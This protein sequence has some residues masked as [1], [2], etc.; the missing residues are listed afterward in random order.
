[1]VAWNLVSKSVAAVVMLLLSSE[2]VSVTAADEATA[3]RPVL[4]VGEKGAKESYTEGS[5]TADSEEDRDMDNRVQFLQSRRAKAVLLHVHIPKAG[6]TA[7]AIALSSDCVCHEEWAKA[8]FCKKCPQ[9]RGKN[10][11]QFD[12]SV[13]RAT[14]WLFGVHL[15]YAVMRSAVTSRNVDLPGHGLTPVYAVMLR[16]PFER[17]VSE[18]R[19]W[20]DQKHMRALDWALTADKPG[21]VYHPAVHIVDKLLLRQ[22]AANASESER[23]GPQLTDY[24][25]EYAQLPPSFIIQN[26]QAKMVGGE[27]QDFDM[28]FDSSKDFGSRWRP[29]NS[30]ANSASYYQRALQTLREEPTVLLGLH[31]RFAE[32]ICLLEVLFGDQHGFKWDEGRNSHSGE[33]FNLTVETSARQLYPEVY[34]EWAR[35]NQEDIKLYRMAGQL[36][37]RQFRAALRL[38]RQEVESGG[39]A[40]VPHCQAFLPI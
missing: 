34:S 24:M 21:L 25:M 3:L 6:G 40:S 30:N 7:L 2:P 9:V 35:R 27:V 20:V 11:F 36:F 31:E 4:V 18:C 8:A 23:R 12:Y 22:H 16:E 14:G 29:R 37:E 33:A 32:Y 13:S 5:S 26:R 17:F 15:P 38:L 1:M 19:V 10:N 39:L 28:S